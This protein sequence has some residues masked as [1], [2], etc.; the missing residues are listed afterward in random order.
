[1]GEMLGGN[2]RL[3]LT[4]LF[5]WLGFEVLASGLLPSL[6]FFVEDP[7]AHITGVLKPQDMSLLVAALAY[8]RISDLASTRVAPGLAANGRLALL[9]GL[10][11]V[12]VAA[13]SVGVDIRVGD[14]ER[15]LLPN[16]W[17]IVIP[18]ALIGSALCVVAF[19]ARVTSGPDA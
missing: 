2:G 5:A 8:A 11:V 7:N 1:M 10:L 6:L 19:M 17:P 4:L 16:A 14:E 3:F 12:A 15:H 9:C 13:T 18:L